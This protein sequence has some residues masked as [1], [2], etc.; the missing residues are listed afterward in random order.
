MMIDSISSLSRQAHAKN[1][2]VVYYLLEMVRTELTTIQDAKPSIQ[3]VSADPLI[4]KQSALSSI[5]TALRSPSAVVP[6]LVSG[7]NI[8]KDEPAANGGERPER[9][10]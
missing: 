7:E 3:L 5:P 10:L 4:L 6:R 9:A 1:L 8:P 2:E